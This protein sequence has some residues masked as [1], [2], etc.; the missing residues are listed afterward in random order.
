VALRSRR[1]FVISVAA[2]A[3]L[4]GPAGR[5][6]PAVEL[7]AQAAMDRDLLEVTIPALQ[8]MYAAKKYTVAQ[9]TDW[10]LRRIALYND[11]YRAVLHVDAAGA[12]ATAAAEDAAARNGGASFTREPLWGV[13]LVI[14]ANTSVKG[15]VTSAGWSGFLIP[16]YELVAPADAT[17]VAKLRAAGGV[18]LGQTN[19]PDFAASDGN[20]S[21]AFGRTGDAYNWRFSPGGS[22]GGTVTSIAANFAL[23][24]NGTDTANSIRM[25]AATS[26]VVGVLP[27]RGLVSIAGIN[28]LDW[29][30]DNTGPIARTVTDAAIMLGVMAGED[31]KDFRTKDS[32]RLA[33]SGPYTK[34]LKPDALQGQRFGVPAFIVA[35]D[36]PGALEPSTR[37]I[38][39]KSL[40]GMRAAGATIVFDVALLP[41]S[42][43]TLTGKVNTRPYIAEGMETFL[44]DFGPPQ[45]HSSVEYAIAVGTPLPATVVPLPTPAQ[46]GGP[47]PPTRPPIQHDPEANATIWQPQQLALAA[48][49]EALDQF[50]LDGLVYPA[51]QMPP[52][53]EVAMAA[54]GRRS[55]GPHSNTGWVNRIGVPAISLPGGFYANGLPFGL[56]ISTKRW[57]DGDLLGYAFA[58]EQATH[59]RR[60]PVLVEKR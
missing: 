17:V 47:I 12:K 21:S 33:Q 36:G 15:L 52:F 40:E 11:V 50:H 22:S 8:A 42:F 18:I 60:P 32:T 10:Y 23:A 19:M 51:I 16:G 14:K 56:E 13:P 29:L 6:R 1:P 53:D 20:I 41:E 58:Y 3:I 27:T 25:P 30:R 48:Y 46:P 2:A 59:H 34:Y 9:V 4:I 31:S 26:A 49:N 38:F 43:N 35:A 44:R 45:Y 55:A 7:A 5:A 24:G 57:K 54:D 39:M 37:E 28:P